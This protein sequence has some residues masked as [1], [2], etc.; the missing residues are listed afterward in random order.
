M[1]PNLNSIDTGRATV[2]VLLN[3]GGGRFR[4]KRDYGTGGIYSVTIGDLNGDGNPDLVTGSVWGFVSALLNR[5]N[6]SFQARLDYR[7][8]AKLK[9][10]SAGGEWAAIGDL[11]G[12]GKVDLATSNMDDDTVSVLINTPGLCTVQN[13]L[14]MT[15]PVATRTLARVNCDVGEVGSDYSEAFPRGFV[16]WQRPPPGAVRPNGDKVKLLVSR[17][18]KP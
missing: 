2:S 9:Y 3:G 12:D 4:A 16:M 8:Q 18:R 7:V 11:N 10:Q 13:V 14:R 17:G 1:T 15:L 6:G 5:G